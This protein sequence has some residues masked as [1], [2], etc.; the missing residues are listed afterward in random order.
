MVDAVAHR[1]RER[2]DEL[3]RVRVAEVQPQQP[4]G[5]HDRELPIRGEVEVVG[6]LDVDR[7]PR[8]SGLRVDRGQAVASV[9]VDVQGLQ[10]PG[11]RDVL[12]QA[13]SREGGDHLQRPLTDHR[14]RVRKPVGD[15]DEPAIAPH[16][17]AEVAGRGPGVQV[18]APGRRVRPVGRGDQVVCVG[19]VVAAGCVGAATAGPS[20]RAEQDGHDKGKPG[21]PAWTCGQP[22]TR[23]G[24][25][26]CGQGKSREHDG[27]RDGVDG[28]WARLREAAC[29][30]HRTAARSALPPSA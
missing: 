15:V 27:K 24:A 6:I 14:H 4:L 26:T 1:D 13:S 21:E 17:R 3:H 16:D 10:I 18:R 30:D 9:I 2:V 20:E 8:A 22:R 19:H 11:R 7:P 29:D 25:R 12:G 28:G 5:D 23:G